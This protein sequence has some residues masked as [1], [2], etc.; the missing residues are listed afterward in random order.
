MIADLLA[1]ELRRAGDVERGMAALGRDCVVMTPEQ[2]ESAAELALERACIEAADRAVRAGA[3]RGLVSVPTTNTGRAD[4][5]KTEAAAKR[6]SAQ[7]AA[8]RSK[9]R[10]VD[11]S[12]PHRQRLARMRRTVGFTARAHD[13]GLVRPGFRAGYVSMV[14]LTYRDAG[15][16]R[17]EHVSQAIRRAREWERR[18]GRPLVYAWVAELQA[19]G[20]MHYHVCIW[21][22]HG[23]TLP[24]WDVQGWWTHGATR[25]EAVRS[26]TCYLLKYLSKGTDMASLPPGA[27]MHGNGGSDECAKRCKQWLGKPSF[28]QSRG[29]IW[30]DWRRRAGGGWWA[31]EGFAVPSEFQRAWVGDR[32]ACVR[33][34]DY[35]RPFEAAGPYS[36]WQSSG[37]R[38]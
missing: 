18:R 35:G 33:V 11:A 1:A 17:P 34:A 22:P 8:L 16:W 4:A 3:V 6:A 13:A 32:Y 20:A 19:R 36:S 12:H 23:V 25:I 21:C 30:D 2:A 38:A 7:A 29:D 5:S 24:K 31:P 27:R 14:T 37:G 28:V 10:A 26:S 15:E 9:L